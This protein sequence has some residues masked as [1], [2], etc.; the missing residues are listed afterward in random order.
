VLTVYNRRWF[1]AHVAAWVE[2]ER[3][4]FFLLLPIAIGAAI[5]VYFDL[6]SEPPLWLGCLLCALSAAMLAASWRYPPARLGAAL[7]LA[8]SVGFAR[9]EWRTAGE[10]PILAVPYGVVTVAGR[11]A[12]IDQ[13][14]N[15]R[16]VTI[17]SASLDCTPAPRAIRVKLRRTDATPLVAGDLVSLRAILFKPDR[18]AYPGGWDSGRDAFFE[19]IGASGFA[20]GD[21]TVTA[22]AQPGALSL[23]LRRLREAI[24][25]QIMSVLPV[26]TGSVA[27][28]LLTGMEQEMP[29]QE[30]QNFIAAGLA[31]ILAVAGLHVGIVMGLFF[32]ASRWLLTRH[33]STALHWPAKPIAAAIALLA[34][35]AYAALTGA[36]LPILRSLAMASLVTLGVIAGRR[37]ISLRGLALAAMLIMVL[38]PEAVIG[39]SFQMSFSAVAALI[40][41]YAAA[42]AWFARLHE[43]TSPAHQAA[44]HLA[45]LFFTS[46]LAGAASMPFAAYQF[47]QIQP[48]WILANLIAV[49]LT[50]MWIMP[51]GLISLALMPLGL[52]SIALAP[53]GWGIGLI[54][55][56]TQMISTWPDA[57]MRVTPMP[58]L[59]ILLYA[60][61]L[62]W[63]CIWRSRVRM[64]GIAAFAMALSVYAA[65]RPPDVLV[66]PDAKLIA[67]SAP[68]ELFLFRAKKASGFMLA[69]WQPVWG[70]AGFA[71]FDTSQCSAD[72]CMITTKNGVVAVA[73]SPPASCPAATLVIS[74]EPLRG[75]CRG[76]RTIDRFSAWRNGAIAVWLTKSGARILTDRQVQGSRPWV[77]SWPGLWPGVEQ[78]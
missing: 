45:G 5:L 26:D 39:T 66:S 48:Y 68:P 36:H 52:A 29:A 42:S 59:A 9:A 2:A 78:D 54:V 44:A 55:W 22:S 10:P 71:P 41:G 67:V 31:H 70:G 50:A 19:G 8:A 12:S 33:E 47:Q 60:S 65:A 14:P 35:A 17:A 63:L 18:P 46:L 53:M 75:A 1:L 24:A 3:G 61:G 34:G 56:T 37:A 16:R 25:G 74:P 6:P 62:A 23:R 27:V 76:T 32:T 20:V 4:R 7:L 73:L 21:I 49:P 77:P 43:G 64:A 72:L 40:S 30:R 69:E 28:T 38:T 51:L 15:G 11:L 58:S 57:M 13:L